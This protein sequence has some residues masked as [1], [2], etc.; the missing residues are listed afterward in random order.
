MSDYGRLRYA[1]SRQRSALLQQQAYAALQQR[2]E[3]AQGG[4]APA[5]TPEEAEEDEQRV[6]R[7]LQSWF[8]TRY[9]ARNPC[10][11]L[12]RILAALG[13][14]PSVQPSQTGGKIGAA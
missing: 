4:R 3:A 11:D 10:T 12:S 1:A 8:R 5:M 2:R 14:Q 6:T 7:G 13:M 9:L